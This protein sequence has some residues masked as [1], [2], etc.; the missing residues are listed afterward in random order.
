MSILHPKKLSHIKTAVSVKIQD[1]HKDEF[2]LK[3]FGALIIQRGFESTLI[4]EG[5]ENK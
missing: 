2:S 3:S 1:E 5:Y 4:F